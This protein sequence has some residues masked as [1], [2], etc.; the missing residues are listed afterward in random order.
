MSELLLHKMLVRLQ[1]MACSGGPQ[2]CGQALG[3]G[4]KGEALRY[5]CCVGVQVLAEV[6]G[7]AAGVLVLQF[8]SSV[9]G[10]LGNIRY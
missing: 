1:A 6:V 5:A 8:V 4:D 3:C 10:R 2:C 7:N 9:C